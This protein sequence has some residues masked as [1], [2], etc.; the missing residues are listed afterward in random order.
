MV[1]GRTDRKCVLTTCGYTQ[2]GLTF[3]C[4]PDVVGQAPPEQARLVGGPRSAIIFHNTPLVAEP[5]EAKRGKRTS[6]LRRDNTLMRTPVE[7]FLRFVQREWVTLVL[8]AAVAAIWLLL[9]TRSTGAES[10]EEFDRKI[11]AGQP[12][13]VE[14]FSNT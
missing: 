1:C 11:Q 2:K 10:L 14:L 13:V 4:S 5:C 3:G 9:R 12:V 7:N 6:I 8:I